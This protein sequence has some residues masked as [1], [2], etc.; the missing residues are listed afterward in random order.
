ME[1]NDLYKVGLSD[2]SDEEILRHFINAE[3]PGWIYQDLY[4]IVSVFTKP[5]AIRSSS[6]LE[7]SHYQP[8]AGIYSTY[9]IPKVSDKK[10][11]VKMLSDGIKEVYAS[12]YYK[13]SKAYMNATLNVIDE[14]KMG[15]ILQE[16]CGSAYGNLYYPTF[17][18]VARSINF[19]PVG[20]EKAEDGMAR[21]GLGLGKLIVE[22]GL[23][24]RFS[25]KYPRKIIQL[26]STDMA[27][28]STQKMFYALDLLDKSFVPSTD[29][30]INIKKLPIEEAKDIA[31]NIRSIGVDNCVLVTDF[32]QAH[33]EIPTEGLKRFVRGLLTE[34][35]SQD[36]I[37]IMLCK[38]PCRLLGII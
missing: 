8:F 2:F 30:G 10:K 21:V 5:V 1:S 16:V 7:D 13:T 27:L 33:H 36:E 4:A 19:Y 38:N 28:K 34:G 17:S 24:L 35:I 37:H 12:V 6:K 26:S 18:G 14:E 9:M 20:N 29:D 25:P 32:G 23:S 31:K 15:I 11:M 22:G 3:L